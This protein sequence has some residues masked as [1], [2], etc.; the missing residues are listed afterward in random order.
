MFT[1]PKPAATGP[2]QSTA[3]LRDVR[4]LRAHAGVLRGAWDADGN[5]NGRP[6]G[7]VLLRGHAAQARV[8]ARFTLPPPAP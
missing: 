1:L 3:W 4:R 7:I 6:L 5:P 8:H 2:P